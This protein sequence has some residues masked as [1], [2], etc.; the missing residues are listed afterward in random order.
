MNKGTLLTGAPHM[1]RTSILNYL[2]RKCGRMTLH[3]ELSNERTTLRVIKAI[4]SNGFWLD[5]KLSDALPEISA[6]V[7]LF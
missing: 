2:A 6:V 4:A 5:M 3:M 7:M 1:G